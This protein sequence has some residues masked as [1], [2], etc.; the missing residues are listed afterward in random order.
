MCNEIWSLLAF[1]GAPSWFITLSPA[2]NRHPIS[3]YYASKNIAF[4]PETLT[5]SERNRLTSKNYVAAV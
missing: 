4:K 5:S 2:D 3:L 1:H